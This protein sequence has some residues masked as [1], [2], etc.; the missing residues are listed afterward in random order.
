MEVQECIDAGD[1]ESDRLMDLYERL[2]EMDAST[3]EAKVHLSSFM[4]SCVE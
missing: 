3:A 4:F 1:G 2:D